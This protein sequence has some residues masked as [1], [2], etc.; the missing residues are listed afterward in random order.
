[1][2]Y[3]ILRTRQTDMRSTS[4]GSTLVVR[5]GRIEVKIVAR[6][7]LST[8]LRKLYVYVGILGKLYYCLHK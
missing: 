7:R 2:C 5:L 3:E 4:R 8:M 6:T 1:M